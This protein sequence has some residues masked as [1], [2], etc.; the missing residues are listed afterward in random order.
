MTTP[1]EVKK[2]IEGRLAEA[3]ANEK[4]LYSKVT[5]L[6]KRNQKLEENVEKLKSRK[7]EL[8]QEVARLRG[9]I[10]SQ[11]SEGGEGITGQDE[12]QGVSQSHGTLQYLGN[13]LLTSR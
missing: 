12:D 6:E 4:Y 11:E 13:S 1:T 5:E 2:E 7:K 3:K 8:K 10:Q 9:K